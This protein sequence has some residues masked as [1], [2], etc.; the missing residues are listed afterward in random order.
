M[1]FSKKLLCLLTSS[2]AFSSFASTELMLVKYRDFT[3]TLN[4][5]TK[6]AVAWSYTATRDRNNYRRHDAFYF[7][8]TV[9]SRCQQT[10]QEPYRSKGEVKYDR[11]HLVP[12]NAMD[13]DQLSMAQ[14]NDM[15][16]VLPQVAQ[17]NRGAWL[18]T[19]VYV[20]CRRDRAP[21]TVIGG[22]YQGEMPTDGNF[23][24]THGIK[25]PE[26]F[27]KVA[28]S[29]NEVIGWWIPNSTIATKSQIDSYIVS[30]AEIE[31]RAGVEI[32]VPSFLKNK[33]PTSTNAF[34]EGCKRS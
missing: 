25:A 12:A 32:D 26:A 28:L 4:C 31:S 33:K 23:M 27:W 21:V 24:I 8:D 29:G 6:S 13:S 34:T 18:Q 9:P 3:I 19:E 30:V 5:A 2:L 10:S 1:R 14:S 7:N 15:I 16:N 20:E 22:V 17:M 11:G